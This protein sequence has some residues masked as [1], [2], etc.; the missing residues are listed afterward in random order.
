[1]PAFSCHGG[2]AWGT[3]ECAGFLCRR[4]AN[5]S[6]I[7]LNPLLSPT[8][9]KT[10][11]A[12]DSDSQPLFCVREGIRAEDAM[13]HVSMLL[14]CVEAT[15]WDVVEHLHLN[16]KAVVMSLIQNAEMARAWVAALLDGAALQHSR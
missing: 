1:M 3:F 2:C 9:Q 14:G 10:F 4:S 12:L 13:L 15:A 16:D 11:G 7:H 8:A 6:P 5:P